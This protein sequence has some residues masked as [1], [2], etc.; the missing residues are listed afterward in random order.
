MLVDLLKAFGHLGDARVARVLAKA[1]A[2]TLVLLG[3]LVALVAGLTHWLVATGI[4]WLD[5]LLP[6]VSGAGA[7]IVAVLLTPLAA[8]AVLGLFVDEVADAVEARAYPAWPP[9]RSLGLVEGAWMGLRL[10][11]LAAVLNL[12][13]LPFYLLLPAINLVLYVLLNGYLLG[14]EYF[15]TVAVRRTPRPA[16]PLLYRQHRGRLT[17]AGMALALVAL[18]PIL[19]LTVPVVGTAFMVHRYAKLQPAGG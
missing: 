16:V 18:V 8:M 4:G 6:W 1:V 7:L 3:G 19:N 14:R 9:A 17:L 10:L 5:P 15:L 13:A 12:L 2:A 11:A